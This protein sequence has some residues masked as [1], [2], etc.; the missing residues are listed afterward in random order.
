[1]KARANDAF[2][3]VADPTRRAILEVLRDTETLSAGEIAARFP[4]ISRAAVSKH[5][6]VLRRA[7]LVRARETGR[8]VHYRLEAAP[9][10]DVYRGWLATFVPVM[11]DSLRA[12]KRR[13]ESD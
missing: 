5:L 10:A 7:K 2:A 13:A 6:G 1:L 8:E 3:A 9:L 11:E 4:K 12:L